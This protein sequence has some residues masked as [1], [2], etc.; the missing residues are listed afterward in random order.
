MIMYVRKMP[1]P[2]A[3]SLAPSRGRSRVNRGSE[4][5]RARLIDAAIIEFAA[6]GFDGASTRM[7]AER[8]DA[9]QS[10]INYH[11]AGKRE[12]WS[13]A[14]TQVLEALDETV[15]M[16]IAAVD[17]ND[18]RAVFAASIRGLV[19]FAARQPELNRIMMHEGTAPS[20]RL[21]WLTDTHIRHRV[22]GLRRPWEH[23]VATGKAQPIAVE[24]MFYMLIGAA[25]LMYANAPEAQ[26]LGVDTDDP[27]IIN[28]HSEAL[29]AMFLA[30]QPR[31]TQPGATLPRAEKE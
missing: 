25:S 3:D 20:D 23:L 28:Q 2:T 18:L 1:T 8:A 4:L 15:D 16:H 11:F 6:R 30:P 13:A 10:Q 19:E 9:H 12:L 17:Q 31:A 14:I 21:E 26:M 24:I 5:V 29:I 22:E 7:I 27:S